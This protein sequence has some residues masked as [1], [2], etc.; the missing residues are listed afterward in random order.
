VLRLVAP[1]VHRYVVNSQAVKRVV[2]QREWVP[3]KKISVIYNGYIPGAENGGEAEGVTRLLGVPDG[4]RIVGIVANLRP[5]KCIDMLIE[6][7]ALIGS[8]YPDARLFIV[9]G[10]RMSQHGRS[11][12]EELEDLASRLGVSERVIFTGRVEDPIPYVNRFTVAVLCSESEGFSNSL[13]EYMEARRPIICTDG[14]GNSELVQDGHN[15][16]LVPV[17]DVGAL[18][19]CLVRLLSDSSL[20]RRLGDAARE[21]VRSTYTQTHMVTE[22][23]ACY[24]E[25]LSDR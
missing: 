10:D 25:V 20:A 15:G 8:Q 11:M 7:F 17:G 6:A 18:A 4:G 9:G 24:N 16:L 14:G 5:I 22:Q 21:T 12:R 23:M 3:A 19:H 13:I 2:Q 1:F